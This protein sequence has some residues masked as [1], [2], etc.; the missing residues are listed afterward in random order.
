[1]GLRSSSSRRPRR[2]SLW[3]S[4]ELEFLEARKMFA[5]I[6]VTN[7]GANGNDSGDDRNAIVAAIN[8]SHDG[9]TI[10]FPAG[11]Y[12][13]SK[14]I[15]S[16]SSDVHVPL[17]H[18][19]IYK[20]ETTFTTTSSGSSSI[21][22]RTVLV[23]TGIDSSSG[24]KNEIFGFRETN[25]NPNTFNAKFTNLTL[26]GRAFY[27]A[28]NGGGPVEGVIIDNCHID[29]T[30]GGSN[31][32]I[33]LT[34]GLR[35]TQIT[36]NIFTLGGENGIY[37][38]NWDNLTIAN[39]WFVGPTGSHGGEGIHLIAFQNSSPNLLIEQ[40]Y[41]NNLHRMAVEIQGG[42]FNTVIQD[43]WYENPFFFTQ[44]NQNGDT[45]AYSI[46][47]ASATNVTV[48]RNYA[49]MP[50]SA[51]SPDHIGTRI[52][53]ELGGQNIQ[54]HDN[55]VDGGND[56]VAVNGPNSTG[57]VSKNFFINYNHMTG[58]N[59][60]STVKFNIANNSSSKPG[61]NNGSQTLTWSPASRG[62]PGPNRRYGEAPPPPPPPP[63]LPD[64]PTNLSGMA[65]STTT[66]D[67]NW[68]DQAINE[69][70]YYVQ[71]LIGGN[72][73]TI[74]TLD[75][76]VTTYEVTGLIASSS[77]QFKV[78]AF[79]AV[80]NSGDS[81]VVTVSTSNEL[82]PLAP[83]NLTGTTVGTT[84]VD[85]SWSD[86]ATN[87]T[88]YVVQRL[89]DDG[90]TWVTMATL[91]ANT[92]TYQ[93]TSLAAGRTFSFR[94]FAFNGVGQSDFS[95]IAAVQTPIA[96]ASLSNTSTAKRSRSAFTY[97][98]TAGTPVQPPITSPS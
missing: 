57:N 70:G 65:V 72:W 81:N 22:D 36:N 84:E 47:N 42:G 95:N 12:N 98:S 73:Q 4:A 7:F 29:V 17:G 19:R 85:L 49:Q 33:E 27:F 14:P 18:A 20:G 52:I 69:T 30:G 25:P 8:A 6:N 24:K 43:N 90:S 68:T 31:N 5:T 41:F 67:L 46:I 71:E 40:N 66:I 23:S 37:G 2:G 94:V 62:R 83:T 55:Y 77:Y 58:N 79:N 34:T 1:M 56:V 26:S 91:G 32:G 88:G 10:F 89:S 16:T 63:E 38:Y 50:T 74:I 11:T 45:F 48:Q 59:N 93:M 13:I 82:L 97:T 15:S 61:D 76:N 51:N 64:T 96:D 75:A 54:A 87:E 3:S 80:G 44:S 21:Q 39:N 53:F 86:N 78:I 28:T 35:N 9:D 92:T 60:G